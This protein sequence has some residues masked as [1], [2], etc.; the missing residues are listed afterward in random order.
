MPGGAYLIE[1]SN[2]G[3]TGWVQNTLYPNESEA[4]GKKC[5]Y[6]CD[7]NHKLSEDGKSCE[8]LTYKCK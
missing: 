6:V 8:E 5:A 1:G 4:A 7:G 3:L 2:V